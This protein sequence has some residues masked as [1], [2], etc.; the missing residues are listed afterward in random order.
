MTNE[1]FN[2]SFAR[3]G[4][5]TANDTNP[6]T[7]NFAGFH[8]T[9]DAQIS[10]ITFASGFDVDDTARWLSI[11]NALIAGGSM[12]VLWARV[13]SITLSAGSVVAVNEK[14]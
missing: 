8:F 14:P 9:S 5:K 1:L 11:V 12:L 4:Y 6:L 13:T 2:I 10:A 3:Y 7:G